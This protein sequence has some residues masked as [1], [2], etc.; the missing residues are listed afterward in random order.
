MNWFVYSGDGKHN[1]TQSAW[2]R[3]RLSCASSWEWAS[4]SRRYV[5]A[6]D[7]SR[8]RFLRDPLRSRAAS[9]FGAPAGDVRC[10]RCP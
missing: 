3:F 4:A 7:R 6:A 9:L 10:R 2:I 1:N 8:T 5:G